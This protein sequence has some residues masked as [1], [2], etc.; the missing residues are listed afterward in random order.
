MK[1]ANEDYSENG[2]INGKQRG[3]RWQIYFDNLEYISA[4]F[5]ILSGTHAISAIL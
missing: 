4:N 2:D 3:R 5:V 1:A